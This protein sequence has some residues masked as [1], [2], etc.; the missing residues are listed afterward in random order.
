[1]VGG[2]QGADRGRA[3]LVELGEQPQARGGDPAGQADGA[4]GDRAVQPAR[5][6][7]QLAAELLEG[8]LALDRLDHP[9]D[10]T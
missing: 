9:T 7:D 8:L 1:V 4:P 6:H 5:A 10:I 3:E 2:R